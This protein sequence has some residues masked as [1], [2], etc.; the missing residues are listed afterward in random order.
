MYFAVVVVILFRSHLIRQVEWGQVTW[1]S[2]DHMVNKQNRLAVRHPVL[3][4]MVL[5][6]A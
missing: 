2:V 4:R 1:Q 5:N 3:L 6:V